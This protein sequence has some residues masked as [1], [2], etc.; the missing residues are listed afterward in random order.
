MRFQSC[1]FWTSFRRMPCKR[2]PT[3]ILL[4]S[5]V[6]LPYSVMKH[7]EEPKLSEI[8]KYYFLS[9]EN[10]NEKLWRQLNKKINQ[11]LIITTYEYCITN[12]QYNFT[13]N[14]KKIELANCYCQTSLK[15]LFPKDKEHKFK[16]H[17]FK[18]EPGT[19]MKATVFHN[20]KLLLKA[21]NKKQSIPF[22]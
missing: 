17:V 10:L 16:N 19:G 4:R 13:L 5:F 11:Q 12:E 18:T 7:F 15:R 9:T 20:K 22:V 6:L 21:A 2:L 1:A 3:T 14:R 8:L